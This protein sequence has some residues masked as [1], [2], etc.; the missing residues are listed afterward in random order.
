MLRSDPTQRPTL[1]ALL[2]HPWMMLGGA[3]QAQAMH[4]G[5][6]PFKPSSLFS[7]QHRQQQQQQ[8][9][10]SPPPSPASSAVS[11]ELEEA[12][13]EAVASTAEAT[14]VAWGLHCDP[15][16][17][18]EEEED[19]SVGLWRWQQDCAAEEGEGG[20][21]LSACSL[22]SLSCASSFFEA[23]CG[24]QQQQPHLW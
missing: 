14:E 9:Q 16:I 15:G 6:S 12:E 23:G 7:F 11:L 22:S 20:R 4:H 13:A 19:A 17:V 10:R 1:E 18:G 3:A 2:S 5:S 8:Q 21:G 24:S